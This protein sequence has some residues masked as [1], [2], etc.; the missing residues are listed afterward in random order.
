MLW[1]HL[2]L[3]WHRA[4]GNRPT[5]WAPRARLWRLRH[6]WRLPGIHAA[7][8]CLRHRPLRP[9]VSW[10]GRLR[11]WI[12]WSLLPHRAPYHA[13]WIHRHGCAP[14][15]AGGHMLRSILFLSL[16][17]RS[18]FE[19]CHTIST[20]SF[21]YGWHRRI[22]PA[23]TSITSLRRS[24]TVLSNMSSFLPVCC[25]LHET[26]CCADRTYAQEHLIGKEENQQLQRLEPT[27]GASMR[28]QELV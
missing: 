8:R 18:R 26:I 2:A 16:L 21:C 12:R 27:P 20:L 17:A 15:P 28:F 6:R 19:R 25:P 9:T 13:L 4:T 5:W 3:R 22:H 10:R 7:W 24:S 14:W 23:L 11:H 1:R